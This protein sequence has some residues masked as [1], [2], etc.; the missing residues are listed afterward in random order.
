MAL[1]D[2]TAYLTPD[3]ELPYGGKTYT[4]RPP[5]KDN[6]R[7]LAAINA[8]GVAAYAASLEE[9][10]TCGRSGSP[11]L[12]EETQA[13]LE[14]MKDDDIAV[15]ALGQDTHEEMLADGVPGTHLD[16]FALYATYYWTLGEQAA[17]MIFAA[18][19]EDGGASGEAQA[20]GRTSTQKGGRRM[21]SASPTRPASTRRTGAH[22]RR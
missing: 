18:Q 22:R 2:L 4:V 9:C 19:T 12:P 7:K 13:L 3:L 10:P 14:S 21:A 15:L 6:G 1:K 8:I 11:D 16:K 5:S 17:D 20:S